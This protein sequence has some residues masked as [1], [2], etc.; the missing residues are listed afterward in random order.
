MAACLFMPNKFLRK[1]FN[2]AMDQAVLI[3]EIADLFLVDEEFAHY[4]LQLIFNRKV[5]AITS[6]RGQLGII[7]W[8]EMIN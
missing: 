1:V 6:L 4:R 2:S 8:E 3:S 7:E 5:D